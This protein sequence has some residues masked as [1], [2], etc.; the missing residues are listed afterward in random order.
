MFVHRTNMN[1]PV[2]QFCT[3]VSGSIAV[4]S[5]AGSCTHVLLPLIISYYYYAYVLLIPALFLL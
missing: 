1:V 5:Q 3:C 4:A 2:R